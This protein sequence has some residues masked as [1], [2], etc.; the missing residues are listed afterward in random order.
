M[1]KDARLG[2]LFYYR[3]TDKHPLRGEA[4][5]SKQITKKNLKLRTQTHIYIH[6][7]C[8]LVAY[9]PVQHPHTRQ[10][11]PHALS[12]SQEET[13][14]T[15][16][17]AFNCAPVILDLSFNSLLFQDLSNTHASLTYFVCPI[18]NAIN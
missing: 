11:E 8:P 14:V 4:P 3:P 12:V 13:S 2:T 18:A 10:K 17:L 5:T 1:Q 7:L 6:F 15:N 9:A 16:Q